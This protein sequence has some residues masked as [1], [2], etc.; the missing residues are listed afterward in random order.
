MPPLLL[1]FVLILLLQVANS[2][3]CSAR[4]MQGWNGTTFTD[5]C[6]DTTNLTCNSCDT[7]FFYLSGTEC[8]PNNTFYRLEDTLLD[9]ATTPLTGWISTNPTGVNS[10]SPTFGGDTYNV[11]TMEGV[12]ALTYQ[13]TLA[14]N[15][16]SLRFRFFSWFINPVNAKS[17]K[18]R[19]NV[20]SYNNSHTID[21]RF[22]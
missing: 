14:N 11:V 9:P 4:C 7:T 20:D 15:H 16:S 2:A 5:E 6:T 10:D 12:T 18:L 8:R 17:M 19:I 21:T 22:S 1:L 3:F 13:L